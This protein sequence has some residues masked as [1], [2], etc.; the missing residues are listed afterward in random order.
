MEGRAVSLALFAL[1]AGS[2]SLGV[3]EVALDGRIA[4]RQACRL[5]QHRNPLLALAIGG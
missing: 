5:P 3:G 1:W 4:G 2:G